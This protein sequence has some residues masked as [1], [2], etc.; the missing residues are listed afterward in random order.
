MLSSR[1]VLLAPTFAASV[2]GLTPLYFFPVLVSLPVFSC[3]LQGESRSGST[4]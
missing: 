3:A 1:S 2:S 4:E